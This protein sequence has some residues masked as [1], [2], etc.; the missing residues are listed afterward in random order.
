[1]WLHALYTR[2][3]THTARPLSRSYVRAYPIWISANAPMVKLSSDAPKI[4]NR[5]S[6]TRETFDVD[7]PTSGANKRVAK[8]LIFDT[9][10]GLTARIIFEEVTASR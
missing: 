9:E 4:T 2:V 5:S 7:R 3:I 8:S 6:L 10:V 1:M